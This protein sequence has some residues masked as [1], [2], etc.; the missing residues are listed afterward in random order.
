MPPAQFESHPNDVTALQL[1]ATADVKLAKWQ[2]AKN[3]FERVL[4]FKADDVEAL[5]GLGQCEL[6]LKNYPAAVDRPAIGVTARPD[7][8]AG[9]FLSL[10]GVRRDGPDGRTR[11]TRRLCIS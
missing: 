6:E 9:T 8:I 11:S 3:A 2:E 5:L 10:T 7:A 4:A 1:L